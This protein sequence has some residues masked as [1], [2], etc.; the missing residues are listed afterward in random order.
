[1]ISLRRGYVEGTFVS[2][3]IVWCLL[4]WVGGDIILNS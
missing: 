1:M 3:Y 4:D 2:G